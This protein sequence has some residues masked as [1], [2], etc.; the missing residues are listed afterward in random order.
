ML[1][2]ELKES[3]IYDF[4]QQQNIKV[5][6]KGD[7]IQFVLC[8]YCKGGT[9]FKKDLGTFYINKRTG[10]F[11][12]KRSSCGVRGNMITLARD[13][14]FHLSDE[15]SHYY[16]KRPT[17]RT[18]KQFSEEI[19]PKKAAVTYLKS[20]GISESTAR[21]YQVTVQTDKESIMCFPVFNEKKVMVNV[22]Y[23]NLNFTKDK[24]NGI[25]EWYEANC[26]PYLYGIQAWD[27]TTDRMILT[28]GQL[29]AMSCY[30]SG[31]PNSFS[32]PGGAN[33]FTWYPP[34]Y[35]F[36]SQFKEMIVFGDYENGKITLLDEMKQRFGGVIKHVRPEDYKDCK[37]ANEILL[38][39]GK[40]QIRQCIENAVM[41]PIT[42][43]VELADVEDVDIA[44]LEK[45]P[46]GLKQVDRLLYGG[47][48][49]GGVH[50]ISGKPGEGKSTLASQILVGA[51]ASG[52]K[53]FAYS[54]ELPNYMFKAWLFYQ[55]A[56]SN[57]VFETGDDV[58]E[59][60]GFSVSEA[61]KN[62]MSNWIRGKAYIYDNSQI[63]EEEHQALLKTTE[64]AIRRYG[65]RVILIDN[66]MTALDLEMVQGDDK[67]ERQSKFVKKLT[68]IALK[69]DVLILLV[70]HKRKNN[71]STNSNDEISGSGDIANLGMVTIAYEK[72]SDLDE[73][74]R[75]VKIAKN[76][77]FGRVNNEGFVMEFDERSKRIYG[78][79]DNKDLE[80]ECFQNGDGFVEL[81]DMEDI[82]F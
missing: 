81:N 31:I 10:Q 68:R 12:C 40:D 51:I 75:L 45:L 73:S 60:R 19:V 49:F 79:G 80:Y 18:L 55:I 8:P 64:D 72:S 69:Y 21:A 82:P 61:N 29:D 22:K 63:D 20:R 27:K 25:K 16:R 54:G 42:D 78:Q 77:L 56:G 76:R 41:L 6:D 3:D 38:K 47:L 48:P 74:K 30:E 35:E 14:D 4:A 44:K 62:V 66:L 36:V 7:E 15:F 53:V 50:L 37:D 23:R 9:G 46:T 5:K 58:H 34:S 11:E 43:I 67:Y 52:Y 59:P 17:Y 28:E 26:V 65:C 70:A 2:Y 57:H 32:V 24:R 39:Y 1:H 13:F 33:G 71:S